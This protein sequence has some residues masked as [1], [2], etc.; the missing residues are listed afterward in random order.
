MRI[1]VPI[2][3]TVKS[4]NGNVVSGDPGDPIRPVPLDLGATVSWQMIS[5]DIEKEV[6]VIEVEAEEPLD[7][8]RARQIIQATPRIKRLKYK[9]PMERVT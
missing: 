5:L 7:L 4:V 1:E 6:M 3:G 2:Q 9:W 8:I